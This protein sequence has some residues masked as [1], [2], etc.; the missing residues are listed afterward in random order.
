MQIMQSGVHLWE[1]SEQDRFTIAV[2][3]AQAWKWNVCIAA[4]KVHLSSPEVVAYDAS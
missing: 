3:S 2:S 1:V 4:Y